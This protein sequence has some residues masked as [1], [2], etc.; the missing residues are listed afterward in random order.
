MADSAYIIDVA[1][2]MPEAGTTTAQ[3]EALSAGLIAAG[4]SA[5][6]LEA[7][8][9][10][11]NQSLIAA[12]GATVAANAAL[13][14]GNVRYS[15][16]ERA[17]LNAARAAEKAALSGKL[18]PGMSK[19]AHE[20]AA[21]LG[22][23]GRALRVL[24]VE[25]TRAAAAERQLGV[26]HANLRQL[27][28]GV[29]RAHTE[30]A[31]AAKKSIREAEGFSPLAK[32]FGDLSDAASTSR[33]QMILLSGVAVGVAVAVAAVTVALIAGTVALA[34]WAVGLAGAKRD[35]AL[36]AEAAGA[37]RP[38][39]AALTGDFAAISAETGAG[40]ADLRG[41]T[42]QLRSANVAAE[43]IPAALRSMAL[44]E[45]ALGQGGAGEFLETLRESKRAAGDLASEV[46]GKLGGIVAKKM[47][48]LDQQS[49]KLGKNFSEL[50][51]GLNIDPVL[52]G[53]R[54]LVDLFDKNTAAGET[55]KFL[56]DSVFQPLIDQATNAAYVVEAFALGFLISLTKLYIAIKPAIKAVKEFFGFED[57]SL[58]DVLDAAK[59]AGEVAAYVFVGFVAALAAVGVVIGVVVAAVVG[60]QVAIY[61]MVAAVAVAAVA[62]GVTFY[63]AFTALWA[64]LS[65]LPAKMLQ[66]GTDLIMGLVNGIKGSAGAVIGAITGAVGG[67]ISSAK[68]LL[69][70]ASP[71]KVFAEIGGF[72]AEGFAGGV[73]DGA[74]AAQD[75]MAAMVEPPAAG[76]FSAFD[77]AAGKAGGAEAAPGK[78]D[79]AGPTVQINSLVI[80][81]SDAAG[82]KAA[83]DAFEAQLTRILEGD[84]MAISGEAA[85]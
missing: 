9:I 59:T 43:D 5:E 13:A 18:D 26:Q 55:M 22:R 6:S 53:L 21:A 42:K 64:Y 8:T 23:E 49:K 12:K 85:A 77:A 31:A 52:E 56:F 80:H 29:T 15:E 4:H 62:I 50:F 16:L 60:I 68:R 35:A 65:E 73:D 46:N 45:A 2:D 32:K 39:L 51:S 66:F 58:S 63:N 3:L 25:A 84:A 38:E 44:S 54:V 37:L 40:A 48:G 81:A 57:T 82:G 33:G 74:S 70:I 41:W 34:A 67:A 76:G 30:Q 17:A 78:A 79:K 27:S 19:S 71:S 11:T 14:E 83:A 20:A 10:A 61:A 24:E 72:T 36:T 1:S 7:A 28:S 75:A 47:L 69:G